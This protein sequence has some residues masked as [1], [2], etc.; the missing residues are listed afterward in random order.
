MDYPMVCNDM[1]M[2][3]ADSEE[4]KF[5]LNSRIFLRTSKRLFYGLQGHVYE[6]C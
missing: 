5:E 3:N 6:K 4:G 2:K 1:L